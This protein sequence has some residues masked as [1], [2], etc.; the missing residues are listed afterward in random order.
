MS[1][2]A[3]SAPAGLPAV[4]QALEPAWIRH[5]STA[6]KKAYESALSFE[7][8]LVEQFSKTL[9]ATSGLGGESSGE[10]GSES[11]SEGGGSSTGDAVDSQLSSMLPQALSTGI[12]RAGGL[13]LAAQMTRDLEGVQPAAKPADPATS[14]QTG[15]RGG[16]AQGEAPVDAG[17]SPPAGAGAGA[18]AS[19]GTPA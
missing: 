3:A 14:T 6:T 16:N 1:A 2:Q 15:P 5:G 13:G 18:G 19:G 11:G 17:G 8:A 7:Q 4:N 10:D 9:T 12:M